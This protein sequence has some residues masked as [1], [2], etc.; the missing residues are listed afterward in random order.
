M[1]PSR[2]TNSWKDAGYFKLIS[3]KADGYIYHTSTATM[4]G[5]NAADILEYLKN[6]MNEEI[7]VAIQEPIEIEWNK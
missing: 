3:T 6:P 5:K 7:L 1:L 4:L 2:N